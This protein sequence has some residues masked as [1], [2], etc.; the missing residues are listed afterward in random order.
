MDIMMRLKKTF[1]VFRKQTY[2]CYKS[3]IIFIFNKQGAILLPFVLIL[4]FFIGLIFLSFEI[5][6]F[7][8]KKAKLSDAIEQATLALTVE[9]EDIPDSEQENKNRDL[10]NKYIY[11]YLP[12]EN[13]SAPEIEIN[14]YSDQ[15]IYKA[16]TFMNYSARFLSN[17]S[18]KNKIKI[19][20]VEDNGVAKKEIIKGESKLTD[21]IFVV[22]YSGSMNG[23]FDDTSNGRKKIDILR[24]IFERLDYT[25]LKINNM[26]TIGFIPFSW[27]TK[28]IIGEGRQ[29][30]KYCYFPYVPKKHRISGD[31]LRQ[32]T[33]SNLKPFLSP[34]S[35]SLVKDIKYG[36]LRNKEIKKTIM[37]TILY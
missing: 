27:G 8:Q 19:V 32:Y 25:I 31:Y 1:L 12:L 14:N 24:D 21:V 23:A 11:A 22:D 5:S 37:L 13:F 9:N 18:I 15:L 36:E 33:A 20:S 34:E 10:V 28:T 29:S 30:K 6:N 16:K 2:Y 3:I 7:L 17:N 26:K 35:F 4:P